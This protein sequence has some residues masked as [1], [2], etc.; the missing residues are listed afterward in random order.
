MIDEAKPLTV[1]EEAE[2]TILLTQGFKSWSKTAFNQFV[3]ANLKFGRLDVAKISTM[4]K[5]NDLKH[6]ST[7][8]IVIYIY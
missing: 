6:H 2:K 1:V 7:C 4:V 3:N 5:G 8:P